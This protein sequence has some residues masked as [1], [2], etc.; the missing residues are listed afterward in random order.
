MISTLAGTLA[1]NV[2]NPSAI[3]P[4]ARP[5]QVSHSDSRH[6]SVVSSVQPFGS[7]GSCQ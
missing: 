3:A 7:P 2:T 6:G 5:I 1:P 4:A